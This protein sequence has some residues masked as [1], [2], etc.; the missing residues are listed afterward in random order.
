MI[1]IIIYNNNNNSY[2]YYYYYYYCYLTIKTSD[3][4]LLNNIIRLKKLKNDKKL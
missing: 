2:Y 1:I 3:R 4:T